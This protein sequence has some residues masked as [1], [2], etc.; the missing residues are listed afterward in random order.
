[1]GCSVDGFQPPVTAAVAELHERR[2]PHPAGGQVSHWIFKLIG[3]TRVAAYHRGRDMMPVMEL[4]FSKMHGLG[5]DFIVFE[6]PDC[7][8]PDPAWLVRLANRHTGIGFNQALVLYPP[9]QADTAVYYRIFNA[10]GGEVEQCGNGARCIAAFLAAR[11]HGAAGELRM[12]CKAGIVKARLLGAGQVSVAM[13]IP[14]FDPAALPFLAP[15]AQDYYE[16]TEQT[17]V[18]QPVQVSCVSMGNPHAVLQVKNVDEAPVGRIGPALEYHPLFPQRA[19]I[20]FMQVLTPTHIRLRVHERGAGETQAC[21]TGAC[22]A[23]AV[24]C[25]LGLLQATV[26]VDLPGGALTVQWQGDGEP[27]WLTGPT[28]TIFEGRMIS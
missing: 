24:G 9:R 16:I 1:M 18:E 3:G 14:N 23:V 12:E 19:N 28:A 21:G 4:S 13:A 8:A 26:T 17:G 7:Q 10:D 25:K 27:V 22:A 2:F 11:G 15:T 5:N 20:G 6:A